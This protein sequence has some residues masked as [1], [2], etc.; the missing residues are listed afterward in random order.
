M[1]DLPLFAQHGRTGAG[2]HGKGNDQRGQQAEGDG[3]RHVGEQLQHH[4]CGKDHRQE[5]TDRRQCGG[6]DSPRHLTRT[7]HRCTRGRNAAPAQAVDVLNDNDRVVYQHTNAQRQTGQAEDVQRNAGK[8]HQHNGKQHTERHA[9]SYHQRGTDVLEEERQY[10]DCQHSTLD[11]VRQHTVHDQL[12]V[13]ALIH[14]GGQVQAV[15]LCHQVLHGGRACVGHRRGGRRRALI[16]RK[17]HGAVFAHL[18]IAVIGVIRQFNVRHIRKPHIANTVNAAQDHAF[19]LVHIVKRIADLQDILVAVPFPAVN[20]TGGHREVLGGDQLLQGIHIQKLVKVSAFQR[21]LAGGF[22]LLARGV[23]LGLASLQLGAAAADLEL[24]QTELGFGT[25]EQ[26]LHGHIGQLWV[27]RVGS[28]A[29]QHRLQLAALLVQVCKHRFAL[30]DLG[31]QGANCLLQRLAQL[32]GALVQAGL[33]FLP[34]FQQHRCILQG[35]PGGG[36]GAF[37]APVIVQRC[38]LAGG[39]VQLGLQSGL[40]GLFALDFCTDGVLFL[41]SRRFQLLLQLNDLIVLLLHLRGQGHDLRVQRSAGLADA[42]PA[43]HGGCLRLKGLLRTLNR[44]LHR[45]HLGEVALGLLQVDGQRAGI[46]MGIIFCQN[47]LAGGKQRIIDRQRHLRQTARVSLE[48]AQLALGRFQF[49]LQPRNLRFQLG[50]FCIQLID[51]VPELLGQTLLLGVQLCL[52]GIQLALG[53]VQLGKAVFDFGIVFV[54][55]LFGLGQSVTHLD[56]QLV[57]HLINFVLI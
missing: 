30:V 47:F 9:Y 4:A 39:S 37:G 13:I 49:A 40:L 46:I 22:V 3:P 53:G 18:G 43:G 21:L 6:H 12:D 44:S 34:G 27:C 56:Q 54:Q 20:V 5:H 55:L 36:E 38:A 31:V 25:A 11:Q 32:L 14:D 48:L 7:L 57:I 28:K 26:Q 45:G 35:R 33:S 17:Q 23:Q 2:H 24:A 19:Q 42:Q 41:R 8:V 29:F 16:N 52:A 50:D 1:L 15:I 10:D 51:R